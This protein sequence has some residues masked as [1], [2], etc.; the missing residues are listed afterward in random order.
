MEEKKGNDTSSC[1]EV[2]AVIEGGHEPQALQQQTQQKEPKRYL[3][4]SKRGKI[5]QEVKSSSPAKRLC[6][7]VD[8][9]SN[10]TRSKIFPE[11]EIIIA[12]DI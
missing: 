5:L 10:L 3:I 4:L 11:K 8:I 7:N 2:S 1:H 9:D 6:I 12:F